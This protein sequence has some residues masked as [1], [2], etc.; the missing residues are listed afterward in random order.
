MNIPRPALAC[1]TVLAL[2]SLAGTSKQETPLINLALVA[3]AKASFVSGHENL[4]SINNGYAP[5][6][7]EDNSHG[8]Y[9]NWPRSGVQ[10]VEYSWSHAISTEKIDVYWY[11]DFRGIA[12]PTSCR[13]KYWDGASFV[14]VGQVKGLGI[15]ANKFNT[16]TFEK[17]STTKLRLEFDSNERFS[18]GVIQ[19]RV[20]DSGET[21][22]FAP[23]INMPKDRYVVIPSPTYLRSEAFDEGKPSGTLKTLW[24][25][26]NGPGEVAFSAPTSENT[27]ATF[28]KP[29]IYELKFKADDG[30]ESTTGTVRITVDPKPDQPLVTVPTT[31]YKITSPFWKNRIKG[32]IV[33]WI[34]HCINKINDPKTPE[35]GI[36]NFVQAAK[37]LAGQSGARHRGA[38]FANAWV[39]NTLEAICW[40]QQVDAQ[41]D[42]EILAAQA[43]QRKTLEDWIPKILAA[44][45]PDGYL[46]TIYTIRG[47]KRWSNVGD[48]EGYNAGYFIEAAI[49]HYK[50]SGGK[51][52]RLLNAAIKLANCWDKNIGPAPKRTWYDGHESIEMALVDLA[53]C[54]NARDGNHLGDRYTKLAKFLMD[55][56]KDGSEYDQSHL[57][58][59]EQYDAEGHAVRASYL[60]TAMQAFA[61]ETGDTAYASAAKSLWNSITNR[62]LYITGGLGSGETSEGFGNDYSLPND[63]YCESCAN[64]G[65]LFFQHKMQLG[66]K[67]AKYADLYED[68]IYNGIL[69]SVDLEAKNFTYTNPLDSNEKRYLWHGCPCCIGN[70]PRT[71]LKLP[72]W[73]YSVGPNELDVN[74]YIGSEVTVGKIAGT[75]VKLTQVTEYPWKGNILLKVN[76]TTPKSFSIKLRV[77]SR[78]TSELYTPSPLSLGAVVLKVNGKAMAVKA[79]KG[80]LTVKRTW[81]KGDKIEL[82]LP[83]GVQRV[84]ADPRVRANIG[85]VALRYGPLVYNI[86][87]VDQDVS[88]VL[89]PDS[90]L[91]M[92]WRPDLLDGVVVIKG[93]FADGSPLL[94]IPNYARLNRGGRSLVWIKDK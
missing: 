19:W 73:M 11:R 7:S 13:L 50:V 94:A 51:D 63:A 39:Y 87:S 89:S 80:Y 58:V 2:G 68:T 82:T 71:L 75:S 18:T 29:G 8:I 76:P 90:K 33:N 66:Y 61:M 91:T 44:Q 57:P 47:T 15:E 45:E 86:E 72:T 17:I 4:S 52:T 25:K 48:H 54:V 70:I 22:N 78:S 5:S 35:G 81:K 77:P 83:M 67:D 26:V 85:R 27:E 28:S 16:T 9:G 20:Y 23:S 56:R 93:L 30:L 34:P 36:D 92:E 10:W 31:H 79:D 55:S 12:L 64:C 1:A 40:A 84:K 38:V 49:A 6:N 59:V 14:D 32:L 74:L 37:K 60:Y 24:A 42:K 41:G 21:A 3:S 69:G 62:K 53:Q 65:E 88:S 43:S 46:H